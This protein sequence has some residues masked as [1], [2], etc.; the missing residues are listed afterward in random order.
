MN[1]D[2]LTHEIIGAAITISKATK[3]G[4]LEDVY[5]RFLAR[6]LTKRGISVERQKAFPVEY[7]G[8]CVDIAYRVD[9]VVEGIVVVEVKA[10][11]KLIPVHDHQVL[12]YMF[13][14]KCPTGLLFNFHAFPFAEKGIKRFKL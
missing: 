2:P 10:V 13:F 9:L 3:V 1:R 8:Y 4:L 12:T 5:E 7:D 11:D 6:E 14:A